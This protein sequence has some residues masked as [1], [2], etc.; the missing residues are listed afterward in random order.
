MDGRITAQAKARVIGNTGSGRANPK[1]R[2]GVAM[3]MVANRLTS[4][5]ASSQDQGCS[6]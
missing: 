4:M 2:T 6:G 1:K 3:M 5:G